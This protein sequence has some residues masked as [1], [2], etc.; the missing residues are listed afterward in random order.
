MLLA[1]STMDPTVKMIFYAVAVALFVLAA[2]GYER[3]RVSF[4][5]AGLA[6]FAFP[7]FWNALA[8][9]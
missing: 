8:E 4:V 5:A 7:A 1:V 2:V 9:T 6:A 3:G